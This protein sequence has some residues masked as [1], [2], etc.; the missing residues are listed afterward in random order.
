[1]ITAMS[2]HAWKR[3]QQR[4]GAKRKEHC[5]NKL[6]KWS[7]ELPDDGAFQRDKFVYI[8]RG[9]VLVT[10]LHTRN[11]RNVQEYGAKHGLEGYVVE[12][13]T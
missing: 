9:G 5:L 10:I 6:K 1:M 2:N 8:V 3:L 13:A 11:G 4:R 12:T 7:A